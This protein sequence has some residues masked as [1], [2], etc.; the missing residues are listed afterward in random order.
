MKRDDI[1]DDEKMFRR[2]GG[3]VWRDGYTKY[4][5]Y[6]AIMENIR[7]TKKRYT[8]LQKY[9]NTQVIYNI[10]LRLSETQG[11]KKET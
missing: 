11:M 10:N 4:F 1:K 9:K 6:T 8:L 5:R 3:F 7:Y 2:E